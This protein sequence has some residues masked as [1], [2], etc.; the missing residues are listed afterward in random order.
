MS[1]TQTLLHALGDVLAYAPDPSSQ[2]N[3]PGPVNVPDPMAPRSVS[4]NKIVGFLIF[5]VGVPLL[6]IV[7]LKVVA[8]GGANG[9]LKQSFQMTL[10]ATLGLAI[11]AVAVGGG[12]F[13]VIAWAWNNGF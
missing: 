3:G 11:I 9:E 7:G 10:G 8:K 2:P 5:V 6:V 1:T 4:V 12:I 13:G